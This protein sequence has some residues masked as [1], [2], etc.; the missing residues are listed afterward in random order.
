MELYSFFRKCWVK[1]TV[2]FIAAADSAS[3]LKNLH[4]PL[5]WQMEEIIQ[6]LKLEFV[7]DE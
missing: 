2:C 3:R 4:S 1:K 7:A 5:P 6:D